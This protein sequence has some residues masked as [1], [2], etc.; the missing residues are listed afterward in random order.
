MLSYVYVLINLKT[1]IELWLDYLKSELTA[2][3]FLD[4]ID[5]SIGLSE[6]YT[7]RMI[8][9]QRNTVF[10]IIVNHSDEKYY[11]RIINR[12]YPNLPLIN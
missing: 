7:E 4:V 1:N 3:N 5:P 2:N 12:K 11:K 9:D 8:A 6:T 10:D